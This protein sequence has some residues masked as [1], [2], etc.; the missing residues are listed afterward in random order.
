MSLQF[1]GLL[2]DYSG[3]HSVPQDDIVSSMKGDV[4]RQFYSLDRSR[5][6][7]LDI[8][9]LTTDAGSEN[10]ASAERFH[11]GSSTASFRSEAAQAARLAMLPTMVLSETQG[12]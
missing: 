11:L 3:F 2:A 6:I 5:R 12:L 7:G 9:P 10:C 1:L 8:Q 4:G